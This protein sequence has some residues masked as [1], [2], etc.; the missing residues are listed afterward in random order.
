MVVDKNDVY[1]NEGDQTSRMQRIIICLFVFLSVIFLVFT[2]SKYSVAR[3]TLE[4]IRGLVG[5]SI[6]AQWRQVGFEKEPDFI[7]IRIYKYDGDLEVWGGTSKDGEMKLLK[8]YSICAMDFMPGTKLQQGDEKTPEG[9]FALS[10]HYS[11]SNWFMHMNLS[12]ELIGNPGNAATDPAF[13]SCTDYPTQ[14][15]RELSKSIGVKNPG[16]AICLHGNCVSA[17]CASMQNQDYVEIHYWMT[18]HNIKQYGK[19]RVHILPFRYYEQCNYASKSKTQYD[20]V[21]LYSISSGAICRTPVFIQMGKASNTVAS[22]SELLNA[23]GTDKI[24]T[25]WRYIGMR[26]SQFLM[27]PTPE[28]AELNLSMEIFKPK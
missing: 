11:S 1:K 13:F 22:E 16:S 18:R 12:P 21:P 5:A 10:F 17:G 4:S 20:P 8:R 26:E 19:P 27:V 6:E 28:N 9:S 25:I 7:S 24:R 15:D 23:L 3:S 2:Y 14:F